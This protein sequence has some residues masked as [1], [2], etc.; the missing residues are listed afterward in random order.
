[1]HPRY[2]IEEKFVFERELAM[3]GFTQNPMLGKIQLSKSF[4]EARRDK[5]NSSL[6]ATSNHAA[7]ICLW[8]SLLCRDNS[9]VVVDAA[10]YA[11]RVQTCLLVVYT[12]LAGVPA[13]ICRNPVV[14]SVVNPRPLSTTDTSYS[15]GRIVRRQHWQTVVLDRITNNIYPL[16]MEEKTV[17][18]KFL[19]LVNKLAIF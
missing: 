6:Q 16:N 9:I 18:K 5:N 12:V 17:L 2:S 10:R 8:P 1:M 13:L 11:D 15:Q 7:P 19:V 14:T 4:T 3:W